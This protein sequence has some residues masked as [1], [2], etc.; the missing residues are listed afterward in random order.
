LKVRK[1][2]NTKFFKR[3]LSY[4][5]WL[6]DFIKPLNSNEL[7]Q[8]EKELSNSNSVN[9]SSLQPLQGAWM[10]IPPSLI[11]TIVI[12]TAT[13]IKESLNSDNE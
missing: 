11:L 7:N 6:K 2:I 8:M 5:Q 13:I 12:A 4:E 1:F 10:N 9:N 3:D